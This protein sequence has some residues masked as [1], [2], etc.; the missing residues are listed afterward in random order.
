VYGNY[1]YVWTPLT[2]SLN[3]TL[4]PNPVSNTTVSLVYTVQMTDEPRQCFIT[5]FTH[6]LLVLPNTTVD[7]PSAFT[8]NGDGINDVVYPAGWGI[9][10]LIYFRIFNRWG[11]MLFES[12]DLNVGWDGTYQ[13]IPQNMETYM[14]QVEVET[15]ID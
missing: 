15:Y 8:R 7:V 1:R 9:R 11:Q 10:K 4:I 12:N 2:L 14:Y 6:S 13:G 5:P 3:D